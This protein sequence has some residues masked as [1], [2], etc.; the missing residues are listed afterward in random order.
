MK[1]NHFLYS[2]VFFGVVCHGVVVNFTV[3]LPPSV[4]AVTIEVF[5]AA[6]PAAFTIFSVGQE[7][8][9]TVRVNATKTDF[10]ADV[11]GVRSFFVNAVA[12]AATVT[13]D[14]VTILRLSESRRRRLLSAASNIVTMLSTISE[15][16]R[17]Q[18]RKLLSHPHTKVVQ[19]RRDGLAESL[20]VQAALKQAQNIR[21][22]RKRFEAPALRGQ[23]QAKNPPLAQDGKRKL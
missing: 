7:I 14:M 11:G 6:L 4:P 19:H 18:S 23:G 5:Q 1:T 8:H 10:T 17:R 15:S 13:S 22:L 16:S 3:T 2:F 20:R 12:G 9:A 21:N